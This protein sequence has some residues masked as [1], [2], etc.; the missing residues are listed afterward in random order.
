[1]SYIEITNIL[2]C[3]EDSIYIAPLMFFYSPLYC[4]DH[5]VLP[6]KKMNALG[7]GAF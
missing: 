1:M 6:I 7:L 4:G 5:F 2:K 3:T